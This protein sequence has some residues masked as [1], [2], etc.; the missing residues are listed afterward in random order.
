MGRPKSKET[1]QCEL[2]RKEYKTERGLLY[3]KC[4]NKK[5]LNEK[6]ELFCRIAFISYLKFYQTV[7]FEYSRKKP[8]TFNDFV[9][10]KFY[11]GF[12]NF[13]KYVADM[14]ML[15]PEKYV[16]FL[17][18]K[19]VP[20]HRWTSDSLYEIYVI[21]SLKK[22]KPD[23]A[24]EK[25]IKTMEKWAIE[26]NTSWTAYFNEAGNFRIISNLKTGKISPWVI[27]N[28]KT[29]KNF[30]RSLTQSELKSIYKIIDPDYWDKAF[31]K[32]KDETKAIRMI[33]K[34]SGL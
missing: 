27:Y 8:R 10:S 4:E 21:S 23:F 9:K 30:I 5:R 24:I 6:N 33:L 14:K 22:E 28:T 17:I 25:S 13:G 2:C 15:E 29:G 18:K 34:E 32:Y 31:S 7:Q 12:I 19:E 1:F 20:L 11:N 3:H 26:S 16:D